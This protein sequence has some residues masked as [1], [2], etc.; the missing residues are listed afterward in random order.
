MITLAILVSL[1]GV[2]VTV[3][4][5]IP[6]PTETQQTQDPPRFRHLT[7]RQKT[8]MPNP[9]DRSI[10]YETMTTV[11]DLDSEV[12]F[13]IVSLGQLFSYFHTVFGQIW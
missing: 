3:K 8:K 7:Q 10:G 12:S 11:S 9:D 2:E 13:R 5:Q 1:I 6:E 4:L